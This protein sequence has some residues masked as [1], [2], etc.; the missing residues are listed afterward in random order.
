MVTAACYF[1]LHSSLFLIR[2]VN[3]TGNQ[4]VPQKDIIDL[5][6]IK[7]GSNLFD[8]NAQNSSKAIEII[9]RIRSVQIQRHLP[10][11]VVINVTERKPWALIVTNGKSYVIDDQGVC[12]DKL[13]GLDIMNLPVITWAGLPARFDVGQHMK[14]SVL[15]TFKTIYT[16]I[17][18]SLVQQISEYHL[19]DEGQLVMYT[20]R[21][22]EVRFGGEERLTEKIGF[23]Q[24]AMKLDNNGT[25]GALRY[26]DLRYK[27][28]PVISYK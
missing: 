7:I 23:F 18:S 17:P 4:T 24:E 1:F 20:I 8:F 25:Q 27:G 2:Q 22:T 13:N 14:S 3:V 26:I 21:G 11:S 19:T 28:Q 15:Q 10:N 6:G 9:P 5:S 16:K 12:F